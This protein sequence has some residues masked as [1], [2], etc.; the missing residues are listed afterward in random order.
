MELK[1]LLLS[2]LAVAATLSVVYM[3]SGSEKVEVNDQFTQFT[4]EHGR[5]YSSPQEAEYRL[6]VFKQ[7]LK[8]I[9][10]TNARQSDFV[11][12]VNQF[13]DLTFEE[14]KKFYLMEPLYNDMS[15]QTQWKL[16][17]DKKDWSAEGKV[18]P[19]KNQA[20]CGSC[21][22]FSTT[23]AL[24]SALA[25]KTGKLNQYSE[26]EL[27]DCSRPYGNNGCNG[28]LM[29]YAFKYIHDKKIGTEEEYPYKARDMKCSS[30]QSDKRVTVKSHRILAKN[31]VPT[32]VSEI[33]HTPVSVAIEVQQDFM[34]YKSGVYKNDHCGTGLNHGVLA[35][36]YNSEGNGY[37]I[38]KNS[39]GAGWGNKGYIWMAYGKGKGTCGIANS[40]DAIPVL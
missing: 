11:T 16:N 28:G 23:G 13:S 29:T 30:K 8:L 3:T 2:A 1:V 22:A 33:E 31:D 10:E 20:S 38:V 18:T 24:E 34:S 35:V 9:E 15:D 25:I 19:V 40:W 5:R 6:S 32:L 4:R 7:T 17:A 39:W 12:G 36:G 27:V 37:F 26:Q 21:W 14:F